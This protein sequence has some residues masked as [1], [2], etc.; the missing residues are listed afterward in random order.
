VDV[1]RDSSVVN[2][3]RLG[4]LLLSTTP[5]EQLSELAGRCEGLGFDEVWLAEDYFFYGGLSSA[6]LVLAATERIR[7]GLGILSCVARHPAVT[8]MEISALDR[9]FPGRLMSGIG[10]GVPGWVRQMG[11]TPKSPMRAL[12]EAVTGIRNVLTSTEPYTAEGEYFSFRDITLFHPPATDLPLYLGVIGKKGCELAGRIADGNI[13]SVLA[14]TEYVTWARELGQQGMK[15]AGR[16]GSFSVP[17]YVLT[18]VDEDRDVARAAVRESVAFY[19]HALG[20]PTPL[21]GAIGINDAVAELIAGGYEAILEGMPEEWVDRLAIS[22]TPAEVAKRIE[23]YWAAGADSVI[24]SPQ[25][26]DGVGRQLE[27]I[28]AEVL[29]RLTR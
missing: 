24:L 21:T 19:L 26:A 4:I 22:G 6:A 16:D 29:P 23:Q 20:A 2:D 12:E 13:L 27:L 8:A 7:V 15:Q 17:T 25:P 11:L 10:H 14:P 18:S 9:S 1:E 3:A 28:A 5:P